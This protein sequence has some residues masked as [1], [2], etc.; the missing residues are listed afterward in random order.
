MQ[1]MDEMAVMEMLFGDMA[2]IAEEWVDET[3]LDVED[4]FGV[5]DP[6]FAFAR[7]DYIE[8]LASDE[9]DVDLDL[10]FDDFIAYDIDEWS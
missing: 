8:G 5:G 3:D 1:F 4:D 10:D 9:F 6:G 2:V 7:G